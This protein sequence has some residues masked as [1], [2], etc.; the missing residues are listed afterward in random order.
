MN[1]HRLATTTPEAPARQLETALSDLSRA[2]EDVHAIAA[3]VQHLQ[4]AILREQSRRLRHEGEGGRLAYRVA[5]ISEQTGLSEDT[6]RRAI[7]RGELVARRVG[8]VLVVLAGEL[9]RWLEGLETV[10]GGGDL[11]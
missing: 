5:E 4:A 7:D 9:Q 1:I 6:V 2:V 11:R 10:R 8:G 3:R